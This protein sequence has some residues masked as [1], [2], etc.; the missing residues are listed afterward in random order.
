ML[1]NYSFNEITIEF[2]LIIDF[3]ILI[4]DIPIE[5]TLEII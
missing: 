5:N 2:K 1:I 3:I 4:S